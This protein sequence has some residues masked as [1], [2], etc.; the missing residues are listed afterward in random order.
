MVHPLWR[1]LQVCLHRNFPLQMILLVRM[2]RVIRRLLLVRCL[3]LPTPSSCLL[4]S[5]PAT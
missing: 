1:R 4:A 3:L 2:V 5:Y